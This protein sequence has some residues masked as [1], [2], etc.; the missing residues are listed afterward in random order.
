MRAAPAVRIFPTPRALVEEAVRSIRSLAVRAV[1]A[2][3]RFA[4]AL[5]GGRTPQDLYSLLAEGGAGALPYDRMEV[6]WSDERAVPPDHAESNYGLAWQVWLSRAPLAA[7]RIHR[8][9]GEVDPQQAAAHYEAEL[10][11]VLGDPPRLDLVLL[12]V[13]RDGHTAS[14]FPGDPAL[15][16]HRLVVATTAPHP[17]LRRVTFT[18]QVIRLASRV[19][20]LASGSDKARAVRRAL[21][22]EPSAAVPA[23]LLRWAQ[24]C[25]F[26]DEAAAAWL[27][28]RG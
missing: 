8:I 20:V 24:V 3:G 4:L 6:F 16:D 26:L 2:C 25:W 23:S 10:R 11:R 7:A 15:G 18:P 22:D 1:A 5:S 13:G 19:L 27:S 17:P 14:L 12:G 21:E 28:Q 9:R